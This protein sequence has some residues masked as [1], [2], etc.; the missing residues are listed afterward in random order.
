MVIIFPYLFRVWVE[1]EHSV[2]VLPGFVVFATV[3]EKQAAV[4]QASLSC[5]LPVILQLRIQ[6]CH[7]LTICDNMMMAVNR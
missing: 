1:L 5:C 7:S 3:E 6:S 2:D 4:V